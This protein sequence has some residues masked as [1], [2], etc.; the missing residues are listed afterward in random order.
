MI[1]TR[2]T[3]RDRVQAALFFSSMALLFVSCWWTA[4]AIF[5]WRG[6][7]VVFPLAVIIVASFRFPWLGRVFAWGCLLA[8]IATLLLA[9]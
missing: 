5:A 6:Q 1:K 2:A 8:Q 7:G 3:G 4:I 9:L